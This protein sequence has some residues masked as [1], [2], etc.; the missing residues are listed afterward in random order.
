[1]Q[2]VKKERRLNK[3]I[4]WQCEYSKRGPYLVLI[5]HNNGDFLKISN[6]FTVA[7]LN[8]LTVFRS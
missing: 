4:I 8:T 6:D 7:H 1:M 5:L 3:M 2:E